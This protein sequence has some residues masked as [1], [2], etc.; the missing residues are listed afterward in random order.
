MDRRLL[1]PSRTA[2][3]AGRDW[4]RTPTPGCASSSASSSRSRPDRS[5]DA[6]RGRQADGRRT[7]AG[8]DKAISRR[9]DPT[10]M[11]MALSDGTAAL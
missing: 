1:A 6:E 11:M 2:S 7:G 3:S 10:A 8:C 5:T 9:G 4:V